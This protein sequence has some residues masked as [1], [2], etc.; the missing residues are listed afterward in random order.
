MKAKMFCLAITWI[1]AVGC[2]SGNDESAVTA[3]SVQVLNWDEA[4][5]L[6]ASKRG[7]VVVLDLWSTTC[8]PCIREFPHLVALS[9]K[10]GKDKVACFSVSCDYQGLEDE[11]PEF[12]REAVLGFLK[13]MKAGFDNVLLSVPVDEFFQQIDLASIPAVYVYDR[14]GKVRKRFDNDR[15]EYGP[16]GFTYEKDIL[17]LV[18]QLLTEKG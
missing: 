1:V 9:Q 15:G 14:D 4:Q 10:F 16:S 6:V 11:P 3:V 2:E 12:Y 17:P 8:P 7:K 18:E 5:Q 13:R